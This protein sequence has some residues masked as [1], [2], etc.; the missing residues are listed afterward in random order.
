MQFQLG[1]CL[2][3]CAYTF[4]NNILFVGLLKCNVTR[5]LMCFKRFLFTVHTIE[6]FHG[7]KSLKNQDITDRAEKFSSS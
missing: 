4:F 3:S 2:C 5:A 7:E 6:L 1:T